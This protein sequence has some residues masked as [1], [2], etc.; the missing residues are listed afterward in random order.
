MFQPTA[1]QCKIDLPN[2]LRDSMKEQTNA[3]S[4]TAKNSVITLL[5]Y[6]PKGI[7]RHHHQ[8]ELIRS[9]GIAIPSDTSRVDDW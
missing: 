4:H 2:M 9:F 7:P 1:Q 3:N 5:S 8:I 6:R